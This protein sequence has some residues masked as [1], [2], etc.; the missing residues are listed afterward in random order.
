MQ[1][2]VQLHGERVSTRF[3][4]TEQQTLPLLRE[5]LHELRQALL[6]AGLEVGDVDCKAGRITETQGH[7]GPPLINEK[8]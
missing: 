7:G 2:Q 3:W 8:A 5:H 4:A 6:N 1:A